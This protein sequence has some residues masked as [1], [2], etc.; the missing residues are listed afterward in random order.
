[1]AIAAKLVLL[2]FLYLMFF[3][4]SHRPRI[5]DAAVDRHLIP[6]R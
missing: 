6:T 1:M 5:D 3:S 4:P 2:T